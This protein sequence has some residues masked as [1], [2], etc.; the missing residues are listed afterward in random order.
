MRVLGFRVLRVQVLGFCGFRGFP[1]IRGNF[2]GSA[3]N[4][5]YS[6]LGSILGSPYVWKLP[7]C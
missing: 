3:K 4:T 6:I 7:Y 1:R 2:F 5:G